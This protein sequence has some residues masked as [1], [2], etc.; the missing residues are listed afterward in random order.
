MGGGGGGGGGNKYRFFN[1]KSVTRCFYIKATG[2]LRDGHMQDQV[3][4][5]KEGIYY[6]SPKSV[7]RRP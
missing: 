1:P 3:C 7:A 2:Q 4:L 6:F 5:V